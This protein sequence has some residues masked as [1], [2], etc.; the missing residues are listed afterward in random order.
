MMKYKKFSTVAKNYHYEVIQMEL[1]KD[2]SIYCHIFK[3]DYFIGDCNIKFI[4]DCH[5][6]V[7]DLMIDRSDNIETGIKHVMDLLETHFVVN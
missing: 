3:D 6:T 7:S 4:D 5:I 1:N 2:D